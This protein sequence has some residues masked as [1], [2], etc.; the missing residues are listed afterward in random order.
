V[1]FRLAT[2]NIEW[3][4]ALFDD[5]G[6]M[7]ADDRPSARY[8]VTRGEQLAGITQVLTALDPDALL[9]VEAPDTNGR[10][11]TVRALERLAEHAGLRARRALIGFES[12]TEQE[13]ALMWAPATCAARHDPG[14]SRAWPAFDHSIAGPEGPVVHS[15]PPLEVTLD[16]PGRTLR[17]VGVHAKSKNAHGAEDPADALRIARVNRIK[18]LTQCRW[19]RGR[20]DER[21]AA[22]D[23]VV[24]LGDLN[25]GP[26][27]D[28][29]EEEF[30]QSGVEAVMGRGA[31]AL[32]DPHARMA[33]SRRLAATPTTSRF[34]L[35]PER[36]YFEALLDFIMVSPD[37]CAQAPQWRIWHPF[38]TPEAAPLRDAL[39]AAS[40]HF[41]VT[42]DLG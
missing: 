18:Q 22:G 23:S 37:L 39:L 7:L 32:F 42:L 8:K 34:W 33:L 35:A 3:A 20:V 40:D 17:L 1:S 31:G 13:I 10:R 30:G 4:N 16:I 15:K 29:F 21:L 26:G 14:G 5:R 25:D 24:V 41:P 36:R 19:I 2:W 11:S 38:N 12:G 27:Q 6:R 9:V 28:D